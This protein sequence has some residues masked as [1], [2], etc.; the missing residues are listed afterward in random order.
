MRRS[1]FCPMTAQMNTAYFPPHFGTTCPEATAR[2]RRRRTG[3]LPDSVAPLFYPGNQTGGMD[4]V[5][6]TSTKQKPCNV[7]LSKEPR[8]YEIDGRTFIIKPVFKE[9][10]NESVISILVKLL[11]SES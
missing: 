2:Q 4:N 8:S 9:Q 6:D 11:K 10:S 5:K 3:N 7:V 1:I